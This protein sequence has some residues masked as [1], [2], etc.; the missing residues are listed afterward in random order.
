MPTQVSCAFYTKT[1]LSES[2]IRKPTSSQLLSFS[3]ST[4]SPNQR[5]PTFPI[6]YV[7]IELNTFL[8]INYHIPLNDWFCDLVK[9]TT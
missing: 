5:S 3:L 2:L 4:L 8:K 6:V 7:A 9:V 1:A